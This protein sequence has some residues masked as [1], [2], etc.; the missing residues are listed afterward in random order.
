MRETLASRRRSESAITEVI[1]VYLVYLLRLAIK[2]VQWRGINSLLN[3]LSP[4]I[5][6]KLGAST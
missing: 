6:R 3:Q 1:T 5:L 4:P 2:Q